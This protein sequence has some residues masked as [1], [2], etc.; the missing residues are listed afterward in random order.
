MAFRRIPTLIAL[1]SLATLAACGSGPTES[2][3]T[4]SPASA[5]REY[6]LDRPLPVTAENFTRAETD[7]QFGRIVAAGGFGKFHTTRT[8]TPLDRQAVVRMNRDTL[9]M[10]AVFDLD[11]GPVTITLPDSGTRYLASQVIDEDHYTMDLQHEAGDY[12][13]DRARIG[14]RYMLVS[15]RIFVDPNSPDDV[16][17]VHALQDQVKSS[18]PGGPGKF[19]IPQWDAPSMAR[20]REALITLA[21]TLPDLNRSFGRPGEVDEVRHLVNTAAAWGGLPEQEATYFSVTPQHN[22][23]ATPYRL[24]LKDVPADGFWS[25]SVY[26]PNGYFVANPQNSYTVNST[27]AVKSPD[28]SVEVNLGGCTA[29]PAPVNCIPTPPHWNYY[30]RLYQPHQSVVSGAWKPPE[31]VPAG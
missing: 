7:A 26:G 22:D 27:T 1:M 20:V 28:G 18:Q 2:P 9:Y 13:Y 11:A 24:T 23:G 10:A 16:A 29:T 4:S 31:A 8:L 6:P 19:E 21:G 15:I 14:T 12:T 5:A 3:A 25:V 30:V 17:K